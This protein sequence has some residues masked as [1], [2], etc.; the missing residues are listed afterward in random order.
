M[1]RATIPDAQ[2]SRHHLIPMIGEWCLRRWRGRR[3]GEYFAELLLLDQGTF[4][5]KARDGG[6]IGP[7]RRSAN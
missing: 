2:A 6:R 1:D 3:V 5:A 4:A 7:W